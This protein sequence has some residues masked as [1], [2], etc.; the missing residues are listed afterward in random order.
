VSSDV[1]FYVS[2]SFPFE[3][4][5]KYRRGILHPYISTLTG[6]KYFHRNTFPYIFHIKPLIF[7]IFSWSHSVSNLLVIFIFKL[8]M[9]CAWSKISLIFDLHFFSRIYCPSCRS[10]TCIIMSTVLGNYLTRGSWY[11]IV[12][13][14]TY[15]VDVI[16]SLSAKFYSW[17]AVLEWIK[18]IKKNTCHT[19]PFLGWKKVWNA[20]RV[21]QKIVYI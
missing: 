6:Q 19:S 14:G 4:S 20:I 1:F 12:I 16:T 21:N 13:F 10:W 8:K 9:W 2:K 11:F 18:R 7:I 5:I 15:F 17:F 3:P